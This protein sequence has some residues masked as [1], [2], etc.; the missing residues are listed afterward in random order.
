MSPTGGLYY[1]LG[2]IRSNGSQGIDVRDKARTSNQK[3]RFTWRRFFLVRISP[4]KDWSFSGYLDPCDNRDFYRGLVH[5]LS[6][7]SSK[8]LGLDG[9]NSK[10]G[11]SGGDSMRDVKKADMKDIK[12]ADRKVLRLCN[13][14]I[15]VFDTSLY[16]F[17]HIFFYLQILQHFGNYLDAP[18]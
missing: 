6:G 10:P 7:G 4:C 17:N 14:L 15:K 1:G 16:L 8:S 18:P 3:A 9:G 2:V 11:S 12:K 5:G 13:S